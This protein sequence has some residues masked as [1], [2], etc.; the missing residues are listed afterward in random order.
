MDEG[1]DRKMYIR[2][3]VVG[4]GDAYKCNVSISWTVE[5]AI[6]CN[7]TVLWQPRGVL[8]IIQF[9]SSKLSLYNKI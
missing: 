2:D 5:E 1:W 4:G 8:I 9:F 6:W 3:W 7:A